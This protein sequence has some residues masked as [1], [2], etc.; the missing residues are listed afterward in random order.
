MQNIMGTQSLRDTLALMKKRKKT[1]K[2][3]EK[4]NGDVVWNKIVIKPGGNRIIINDE[5]YDINPIFRH[6]LLKRNSQP[7]VWKMKIN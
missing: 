5:E 6:L 2:K 4:N 7:N 3:E 1:F